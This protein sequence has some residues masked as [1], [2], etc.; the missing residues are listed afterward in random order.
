MK[1]G[2][3]RVYFEAYLMTEK[4]AARN[5]I[6]AYMRDITQFIQFLEQNNYEILTLDLKE[7]KEFLSFLHSQGLSGRS[8]ARKIS[9]LKLFFTYCN[10]RYDI[11]D[12]AQH[13]IIPKIEKRLPEFLT[14]TE[15][16]YLFETV[17][18]DTTL[19]GTRDTVML[20]LLYTSG[21]RVSELISL[22][23]SDIAFDTGCIT[24][25]GK[26]GKERLVPLL[27]HILAMLRNYMQTIMPHLVTD[28]YTEYLFPIL[29]GKQVK[30]M[31][32][33]WFWFTLKKIWAKTGI[34]KPLS[35][36]ILRHSF[37]THLLKQGAHLRSLQMLLGHENLSTVQIYTHLEKSYVRTLY[38]KKH[39]RS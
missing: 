20:Y 32:R 10:K 25:R 13:L 33:Q 11:K 9:T 39:P 15:I 22:K 36:H 6:D 4:R 2:Q 3:L 21:M 29:Y 26:G 30:P 19:Q 8:L 14:E 1:N 27:E 35:P 38:D 17:S 24:I 31:T 7:L 23:K 16:E 5:T 34:H 12:L 37:A 18:K 28:Q